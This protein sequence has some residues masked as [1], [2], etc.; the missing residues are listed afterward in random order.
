MTSRVNVLIKWYTMQYDKLQ[1]VIYCEHSDHI[2]IQNHLEG[3]KMYWYH[4]D[5]I[6]PIVPE[7]KQRYEQLK[8]TYE[9]YTLAC[10]VMSKNPVPLPEKKSPRKR[11]I[12]VIDDDDEDTISFSTPVTQVPKVAPVATT[13][14]QVP[15][16]APV[17]TTV[18]QLANT[19][20]VSLPVSPLSPIYD[21]FP[22][23]MWLQPID[24]NTEEFDG[25]GQLELPPESLLSSYEEFDDYIMSRE[26]Y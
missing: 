14:A 2:L 9:D 22:T 6:P 21:V 4:K 18:T 24:N 19:V 17:S 12:I 1:Y 3:D 23:S 11:K 26:E 8:P 5:S 20:S 7:A 25:Y 13:V 16:V 10:R 15:K